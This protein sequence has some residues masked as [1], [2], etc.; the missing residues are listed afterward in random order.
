MKNKNRFDGFHIGRL[1][2]VHVIVAA[3][4]FILLPGTLSAQFISQPV[5]LAY[6]SQR[7]DVIVQGRVTNVL[8]EPLAGYPNIRTV[9]VTINVEN[10]L[11]GT[12]G[13]EYT[14]REIYLG[15]QRDYGKQSYGVG[16]R[17]FLFLPSPSQYGLSSP[18]GTGQGRFH[19]GAGSRGSATIVNEQGNAGLFRNVEQTAAKAGKRLTTNQLKLAATERGPVA[20]DDFVSLVKSLM[21]LPRIR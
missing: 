12:M 4:V 5:N 16:Q 14:F 1:F 6:L 9:A 8:H 19:I 15:L 10:S 17:L 13:K 2:A 11:R 7:A 20:L 18:I 3:L 21:T